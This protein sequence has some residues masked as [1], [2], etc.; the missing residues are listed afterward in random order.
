MNHKNHHIDCPN[1]GQGIDVNTVLYSKV[2]SELGREFEKKQAAQ[3][4]TQAK[5]ESRLARAR[6]ELEADKRMHKERL[7]LAI[8]TGLK[9]KEADLRIQIKA[10]TA[11]E[12]HAALQALQTELRDK[13]EKLKRAHQLEAEIER[14]KRDNCEME[15]SIRLETQKE[16]NAELAKAKVD[17]EKREA[18]K[19]ELILKEKDVQLAQLRDQLAS[20]NRKANQGSMQLQGEVQELA[21]EAWLKEQFPQDGVEEIKKGSRGADCLQVINTPY[22]PQ[23]GRILYES[24]RTKHFQPAWVEK[25]KQD[26]REQNADIGVLVTEVMPKDMPHFGLKDGIYICTFPEFKALSHVLRHSLVE[27]NRALKIEENKGDIKT[28]LYRYFTS[29][30]FKGQ[31]EAIVDGFNQ[32]HQDLEKEKRSMQGLWK[33]REKQLNK[34]LEN[35]TYLYSSVRGIGGNSIGQVKTLELAEVQEPA[36]ILTFEKPQ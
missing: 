6:A 24:K 31:I 10:E 35:T 29:N 11:Q 23:A 25:F 9:Q 17:I 34:V 27:L 5:Q 28:M 32:M 20:A 21:I 3:L 2:R 36:R 4:E 16:L 7:R 26:I 19:A 33:K 22:R 30:E 1:C 14:L 15:D 18:E 8:D 13:T 12:Q